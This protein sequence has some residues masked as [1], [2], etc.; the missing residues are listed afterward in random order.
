[1]LTK[2]QL[3]KIANRFR[4][5]YIMHGGIDCYNPSDWQKK[6]EKWEVEYYSLLQAYESFL[7]SKCI[8][9]PC[10]K[11]LE[12]DV[13]ILVSNYIPYKRTSKHR[14]EPELRIKHLDVMEFGEYNHSDPHAFIEGCHYY[15]KKKKSKAPVA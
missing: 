7:C 2:P 12:K 4:F 6:R 10:T 11:K 9:H 3:K 14:D 13:L 15:I 8:H 5:L 1:M